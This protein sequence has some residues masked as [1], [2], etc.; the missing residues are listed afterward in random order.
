MVALVVVLLKE[1]MSQ[2]LRRAVVTTV[3]D[4]DGFFSVPESCPATNRMTSVTLV[5]GYPHKGGRNGEALRGKKR[6]I[7]RRH[8]EDTYAMKVSELTTFGYQ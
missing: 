3:A 8:E 6:C 2:Y 4:L 1:K 7:M 5:L